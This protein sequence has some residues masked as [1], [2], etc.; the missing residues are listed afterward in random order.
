MNLV[1][2]Y[3]DQEKYEIRSWRD[4][5]IEDEEDD[6]YVY[7]LDRFAKLI[8]NLFFDFSNQYFN[9]FPEEKHKNLA[10]QSKSMLLFKCFGECQQKEG[11]WCFG[12]ALEHEFTKNNNQLTWNYEQTSAFKCYSNKKTCFCS[13]SSPKKKKEVELVYRGWEDLHQNISDWLLY[14]N[15]Q[16]R[17]VTFLRTDLKEV[18]EI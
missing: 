12:I 6:D 16:Y 5:I 4:R 10:T 15:N 14:T 8:C 18:C 3:Y 9:H 13:V 1:E 7:F 2:N 17:T 11:L